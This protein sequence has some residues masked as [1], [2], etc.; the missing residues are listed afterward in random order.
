MKHKKYMWN[1]AAVNTITKKK[2]ANS[3]QTL[4]SKSI[5]MYLFIYLFIYL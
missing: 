5:F 2:I 4:H 3:H 1:P